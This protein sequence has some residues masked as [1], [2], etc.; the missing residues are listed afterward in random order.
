MLT[1]RWLVATAILFAKP[2]GA[3]DSSEAGLGRRAADSALSGGPN[4]GRGWG[5]AVADDCPIGV[6]AEHPNSLGFRVT[7]RRWVRG[8]TI[9]WRFDQDVALGKHWGPVKAMK[10]DAVED[11][12]VLTFQLRGAAP[13]MRSLHRNAHRSDQWGFVLT[14]PYAG[15]WSVACVLPLS[16]PPPPPLP[17]LQN[18]HVFANAS[19]TMVL[20]A[21]SVAATRRSTNRKGAPLAETASPE[22][23]PS[24][25]GAVSRLAWSIA[26]AITHPFA[27]SSSNTSIAGRSATLGGDAKRRGGRRR[28]QRRAKGKGKGKGRGKAGAR[29]RDLGRARRD[30]NK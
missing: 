3:S 20:D 9:S 29:G 1:R 23:L 11:A 26:S 30:R 7:V 10:A 24:L 8:A 2:A 21:G 18:V 4:N 22:Q 28:R 19:N 17:P 16:P 14:A 6:S 15:H 27:R 5:G 13:T 12:R 25:G